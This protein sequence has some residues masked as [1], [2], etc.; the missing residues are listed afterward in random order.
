MFDSRSLPKR[1]LVI[2]FTLAA[3]LNGTLLP[4]TASTPASASANTATAPPALRTAASETTRAR[5]RAA[6]GDLPMRFERNQG[7][8]DG[9][10]KF[11]ARG[12]GYALWLTADEAVLSLHSG[13]RKASTADATRSEFAQA[14]QPAKARETPRKPRKEARAAVI[15][16]RLINA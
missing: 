11:A 14:Q 9:R 2:F 5:V 3:L 16:M 4:S 13:E 7:Q 8:F 6:Y 10:V 1:L 15:H 12:A